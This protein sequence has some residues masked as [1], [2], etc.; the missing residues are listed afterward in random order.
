MENFDLRSSG[1]FSQ[2]IGKGYLNLYD[3]L[4]FLIVEN[5]SKWLSQKIVDFPVTEKSVIGRDKFQLILVFL[6]ILLNFLIPN[7]ISDLRNVQVLNLIGKVWLRVSCKNSEAWVEFLCVNGMGELDLNW[8]D[9]V[10]LGDF[11]E[12]KL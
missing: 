1:T 10:V 11:R 5:F 12:I 9:W 7:N 6:K 2:S 3:I 4:P 8:T